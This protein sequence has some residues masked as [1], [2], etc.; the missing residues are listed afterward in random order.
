[1]KQL[2]CSPQHLNIF[3][4]LISRSEMTSL[5]KLSIGLTQTFT[6][7]GMGPLSV[8]TTNLRALE[9]V[10]VQHMVDF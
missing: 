9:V 5:E 4:K 7:F 6:W 10:G 3:V 2:S 1:M 8:A